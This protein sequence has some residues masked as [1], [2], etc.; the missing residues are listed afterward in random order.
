MGYTTYFNGSFELSRK[1]T[2][3]EINTL[4]AMCA[5]ET[6]E[7]FEDDEDIPRSYGCPWV[8]YAIKNKRPVHLE[9]GV[10]GPDLEVILVPINEE[11]VYDWDVWMGYLAEKLF[12]RW[13]VKVS[14]RVV[15][16]GEDSGDSGVIF[17]K[18]NKV[19]LVNIHE[20]AEFMDDNCDDLYEGDD[21]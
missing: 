3:S 10:T 17:A 8:P 20:L 15:W 11:K 13:G 18:D 4:L 1:L 12:V 7:E 2:V 9:R 16:Q 5:E 6:P 14:G 19:K 21:A